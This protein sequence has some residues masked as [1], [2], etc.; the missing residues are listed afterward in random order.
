MAA[1]SIF[2]LV[3]G[4]VFGVLIVTIY[5]KHIAK[6]PSADAG[7]ARLRAAIAHHQVRIT[8][9]HYLHNFAIEFMKL[10]NKELFSLLFATCLR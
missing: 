4:W 6:S 8:E 7:S 10:C 1:P 5:V 2:G 9:E 3:S